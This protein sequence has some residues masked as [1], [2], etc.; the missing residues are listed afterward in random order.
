[1]KKLSYKSAG[2]DLEFA[3]AIV[4]VL[5]RLVKSTRRPEV[6]ADVGPFGSLVRLGRYKKPV[7]VAS[8]DGVGN[9]MELALKLRRFDTI[10]I[11]LVAMNVN[12]VLA[13]GAEPLFFLDYVGLG[14]DQKKYLPDLI[15]GIA[16]GCRKAGCSLVGG[17]TAE[18]PGTYGGRRMGLAGFAVGVAEENQIIDGRN[19]REGDAVVGLASSGIHANGFSLVN[20][21]FRPY[22]ALLRP[23]RIYTGNVL[24][25]LGPDIHGLSHITGGG[26][27][28]NIARILPKGLA[29]EIDADQWRI[30]AIFQKIQSRSGLARRD[31]FHT[32]NM[33]I[34]F[35]VVV[36]SESQ[37]KI[38]RKLRWRDRVFPIGTIVRGSGG[39]MIDSV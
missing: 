30:P 1:M 6:I 23:T 15:R 2:V 7:L 38:M 13:M 35:V 4:P 31:M 28:D 36:K 34:G 29:C 26:L 39:V 37:E 19:I 10:G 12:D 22:P 9:K 14:R 11:D 18:M 8:A 17:E 33:G 25:V 16:E 24:S 21:L 3:N 32:F 27:F 5:Q 20:R